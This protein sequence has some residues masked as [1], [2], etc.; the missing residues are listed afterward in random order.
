MAQQVETSLLPI[1]SAEEQPKKDDMK[2]QQQPLPPKKK[3]NQPGMP[4]PEAEVVALSPKELLATNRFICEICGKGFQRDQNLQLHRR[5]H[6]LPWKL[7]QR[8]PKEAIKKRVY[9]CPEPE[10]VHHDPRRALGDLTGIKKHFCRKHGEK[11]WK[12]E[13]CGKKYAVQSDWKAHNKTCGTREYKCDCGTIFSRRD[14]FVTHRA[15]CDALAQESAKLPSVSPL[16]ATAATTTATTTMSSAVVSPVLSINQSSGEMQETAARVT[17]SISSASCSTSS[18]S[19]Y[20][21]NDNGHENCNGSNMVFQSSM[22]APLS[23]FSPSI[24]Q[25]S[26]S[27]F[28]GLLTTMPSSDQ[29]ASYPMEPPPVLSLS[30]LYQ[31]PSNAAPTLL[32]D[33]ENYSSIPQPTISATALLQKAAE[34]GATVSGSSRFCGLGLMQSQHQQEDKG[35]KTENDGTVAA[36]MIGL[37]VPSAGNFDGSSGSMMDDPSGYFGSK[38]MTLDLLGLGNSSTAA[39]PAYLRSIG[40]P[41]DVAVAAFEGGSESLSWDGQAAQGRPNDTVL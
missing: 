4:D 13:R 40:N 23:G 12:C 25:N 7:R 35:V 3:R 11:K 36:D 2:Q 16:I 10:C 20:K 15:F 1:T 24:S 34:M 6:N 21:D 14:S 26:Q 17:T 18:T 27:S 33:H 19:N 37:R 9:V 22:F 29:L 39:F 8:G 5:G 31:F 38:P 41:I 28:S 30:T 32:Q